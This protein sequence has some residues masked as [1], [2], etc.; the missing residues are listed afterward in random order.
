MAKPNIGTHKAE[1]GVWRLDKG[2]NRVSYDRMV[3]A[4]TAFSSYAVMATELRDLIIGGIE[5]NDI[6]TSASQKPML[7]P[8]Q[9]GAGPAG[10]A[11]APLPSA[12]SLVR[13][14]MMEGLNLNES[15][16]LAIKTAIG[17]RLS[18][19]QVSRFV[20]SDYEYSGL[21]SSHRSHYRDHLV[22][23]RLTQRSA[24]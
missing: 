16:K 2:A 9:R 21:S 24:F 12:A 1:T 10:A 22:L 17:R 23:V 3:S 4:I 6:N 20:C 11:V 5:K 7:L 13:P 19:I 8:Y 14:E 15:Q 18:I